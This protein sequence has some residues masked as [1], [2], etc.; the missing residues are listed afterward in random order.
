MSIA[1]ASLCSIFKMFV[2]C[3]HPQT[4]FQK[5]VSQDL[6]RL[7]MKSQ[8]FNYITVSNG[9]KKKKN[10]VLPTWYPKPLLTCNITTV[11]VCYLL[12]PTGNTHRSRLQEPPFCI[13]KDTSNELHSCL[14]CFSQASKHDLSAS[15]SGTVI[16][17]LISIMGVWGC[18]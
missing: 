17:H 9:R 7:H 14:C 3:Q 5:T 15:A 2:S 13:I 18:F 11:Q 12:A 6:S 8:G 16:P 1:C 10:A 4:L